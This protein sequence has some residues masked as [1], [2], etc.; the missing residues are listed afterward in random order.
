M[1]SFSLIYPHAAYGALGPIRMPRSRSM[2]ELVNSARTLRG[3]RVKW[4][5]G[6]VNMVC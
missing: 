5:L 6:S 3:L 1:G 2:C 4:S